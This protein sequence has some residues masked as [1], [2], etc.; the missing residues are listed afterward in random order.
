MQP[1]RRRLTAAVATGI[2]VAVLIPT[3]AGAEESAPAGPQTWA[4]T[5]ANAEGPD[6]R[7]GLDYVVEPDDVYADH[8]AVRNLGEQPLTVTLYAHDA[9]Q[10]VDNEFEV[11]TPGDRGT[12]IGAWLQLDVDE[13]TVPARDH[14]IVPFTITVPADAEPGDHAGGIVA[15]NVPASGAGATMQYRVGTRVHL[16]VG[17]PVD[18]ALDVDT[19]A[20]DYETRW[21]PFASGPLDVASTLVNT[22]N[23]RL[24]PSA[25]VSASG[26]F[27]WWNATAELEG[28]GEILP[29][30]AQSGAAL[31]DEVPAIGPLW[32]TVEVV[33]VVSNGQDVTELTEVKSRTIVVWAVPW[34]LL[35]TA[36]LLLVALV[37]AVRNLRLRRRI[38]RAPASA[39][40]S[41]SEPT[42]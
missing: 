27:G 31:L 39:L 12:G 23:V 16:R 32:V 34:V 9:V 41:A 22:G 14:V 26:L 37:I 40:D 42:A 15:V 5:P 17:G 7:A 29:D 21:T 24:V 36:L 13:V 10:T 33:E 19:L 25:R 20:A 2:L 11:L 3:W 1:T 35:G 6:G 30:G 8:I 4:V 38:A 18:A 28:I